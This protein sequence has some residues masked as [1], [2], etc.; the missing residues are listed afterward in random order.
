M[1]VTP[2]AA[3]ITRARTPWARDYRPV[4]GKLNIFDVIP[5]A[6]HAAI[7]AR[8][9]TYN[10]TADLQTAFAAGLSL[11]IPKGTYKIADTIALG[12][13]TGRRINGDGGGRGG[14]G[15]VR[16]SWAG[17]N[18]RPMFSLNDCSRVRFGGFTITA[19]TTNP[20]L[21]G[22][23]TQNLAAT[24]TVTS[25][26]NVFTD[27][28]MDGTNGGIGKGFQSFADGVTA[29]DGNNDFMRFEDCEVSNYGIAGW[30][31]EHSQAYTN[32]LLNCFARGGAIGQ[33]GVASGIGGSSQGG[34][35]HWFG[36]GMTLNTVSDFYVGSSG[37][38]ISIKGLDSEG[39]AKLLLT[40]GPLSAPIPMRI[41]SVRWAH[42]G[43]LA[44]DKYF[45]DVMNPGPLTV[46]NS[47]F[48]DSGSGNAMAIRM[49][50]GGTQRGQITVKNNYIETTV[51]KDSLVALGGSGLVDIEMRGNYGLNRATSLNVTYDTIRPR[52]SI[53]TPTYATSFTPNPL[54]GSTIKVGPLTGTTTI[55]AV[56]AA[57][58]VAGQEMT[59]LIYQDATGGRAVNFNAVYLNTPTVNTAANAIT[60][61]RFICDGTNWI[62]G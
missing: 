34:S 37:D 12:S 8:A 40:A 5:K 6:E 48:P 25:T 33:Y 19:S 9:S 14:A 3:R 59:L 54:K 20:L 38:A 46:V 49:S 57:G 11:V 53:Q 24:A 42:A 27:I 43:F 29:I 51:A 23:R 4:R 60:V 36:G 45:I 39:S 55:G 30:S 17:A 22:V 47:R 1:A 28:A 35:F 62:G 13:V 58:A 61:A 10:A 50:P 15:E 2:T 56:G 18:D 21:V 52:G 41:E 44:A 7:M 32:L 16:F 26:E 31:F